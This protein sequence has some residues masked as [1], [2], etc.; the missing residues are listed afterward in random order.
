MKRLLQEEE[1]LEVK[2]GEALTV[3][4]VIAVMAVALIGVVIYRF[5]M[6]NKGSLVLPGGY[7]FNWGK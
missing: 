7:T 3:A 4:A 6:S 5:F 1:M 2:G